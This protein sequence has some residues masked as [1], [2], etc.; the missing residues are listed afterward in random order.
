MFQLWYDMNTRRPGDGRPVLFVR[1]YATSPGNEPVRQWLLGLSPR[2]RL[3]VGIDI[4][5][6]QYG[7]PLGMPLVR[8]LDPG[9]WEVRS[10]IVDG[11]ARVVFTVEGPSMVLL[12]GFVKKSGNM[13]A[14][15]LRIARQRARDLRKG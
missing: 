5:A 4:K 2:D 9:L 1:F 8:K 3:A 11:S 12:H 15:D 6:V 13:P 14:P 10:H 7:W